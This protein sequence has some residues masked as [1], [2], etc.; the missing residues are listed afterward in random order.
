MFSYEKVDFEIENSDVILLSRTYKI[1][2]TQE[3]I[4]NDRQV[5]SNARLLNEKFKEDF[6]KLI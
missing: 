4:E 6:K 5:I 3:I 2:D 1:A